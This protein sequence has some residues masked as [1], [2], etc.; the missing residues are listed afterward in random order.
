V[1]RE[2]VQSEEFLQIDVNREVDPILI[3]RGL[4][5][6][7]GRVTKNFSNI[8]GRKFYA[9]LLERIGQKTKGRFL[10]RALAGVG[11]GWLQVIRFLVFLRSR[12]R[13]EEQH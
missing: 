11:I 13:A 5:C 2:S 4:F 10:Y 6:A 9:V 1:K 3:D 12:L 8:G 7:T